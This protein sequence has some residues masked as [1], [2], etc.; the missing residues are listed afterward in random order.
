MLSTLMALSDKSQRI[1]AQSRPARQKADRRDAGTAAV[2]RARSARGASGW[3]P[4]RRR[5]LGNGRLTQ[6]TA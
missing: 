3:L 1:A 6:R 4:R 2:S 5:L